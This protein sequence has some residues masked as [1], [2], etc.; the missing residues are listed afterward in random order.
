LKCSSTIKAL[1]QINESEILL[2]GVSCV[3]VIDIPTQTLYKKI[4]IGKECLIKSCEYDMVLKLI[5]ISDDRGK[6]YY[7]S[8]HYEL[9]GFVY[10]MFEHNS[11]KKDSWLFKGLVNVVYIANRDLYV[12][13]FKIPS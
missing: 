6:I 7:L 5:F 3:Y 10:E 2:G 8:K 12:G 4:N 1:K 11:N 9:F 13:K